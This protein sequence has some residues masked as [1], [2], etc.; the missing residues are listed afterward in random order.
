MRT[1]LYFRL[2]ALIILV[3]FSLLSGLAFSQSCTVTYYN[4]N[5]QGTHTDCCA[6]SYDSGG[7]GSAGDYSINENYTQTFYTGD[8]TKHYTVH[9][10]NFATESGF[11]FLSAYDGPNTASPLLGTWSGTTMPP[12][13]ATS[14]DYL[15]LKFTSDGSI[16]AAGWLAN[17]RCVGVPTVQ[18]CMG[19]IPICNST[20]STVVAYSGTGNVADEIP[21]TGGCP[22][23][24]CLLSGEKNDVWYTFT[25]QTGGTLNFDIN[26][27]AG[28]DDY[29]WAVYDLTG[30]GC[31]AIA[32][33]PASVQV[34]CNYSATDGLTGPDGGYAQSCGDASASPFNDVISAAAGH[35]YVINISNFTSSQSGYT[36]N[37]GGS[38]VVIDNVPPYMQSLGSVACGANVIPV[39]FSENLL[40]TSV[41]ET[42]F[43]VTGPGGP[44]TVTNVSGYGCQLNPNGQEND[45]FLTVSPALQTSG[46]YTVAL[47]G[48]AAVQD[49]CGNNNVAL[50]NLTFSISGVAA[51][52]SSSTNETCGLSNGSVTATQ[53]GGV[54]PYSYSWSNGGSTATISSL[55]AGTYTCTVTDNG[56]CKGI[57]SQT[58]TSSPTPVAPTS[59]TAD[60]TTYCAGAYPTINLSAAGGSGTTLHW[61]TS[62]G[63]ADIGTGT[64]LNIAAPASTTT[65]YAWWSNACG[66]STCQSVTITVNP[67]PVAPTSATADHTTF[68]AGAYP[69]INLSAAGGSGT[70]LH[71]STSCGG[72]DIGTGTPLNIA[73]PA[74]TTTYYAWWSNGCGNTTCQSVTVTVN[75]LPVAPTSASVDHNNF[76]PSTWPTINLSAVGGS[77]TTLNWSTSCGGAVI[78]TGTPLNIASPASTTTYYAWWT[79]GCGSTTCQSVTVNILST[80][81]P[82]TSVVVDNNNFCAGDYPTIT[83]TASGGSGATMN[84]YSG[85]CGGTSLGTGNPKTIA[86]P[87][88]TTT[89]YAAW[90]DACGT[91]TC[92][93]VTVNINPVPLAPTSATADFTT[94]CAG[95]HPTINLSAVGG[96]GTTLNWSTSCGGASIGTGTPLNIAA[97]ATTTTYYAY[98]TTSCGNSTCASVTITINPLPV[99]PTSANVDKNNFCPSSFPNITLTAAGGSGSTLNWYTGSCGGTLVGTGTPLIIAAPVVT[100]T[101]Y[102]AWSN[103]CGLSSCASITVNVFPL[104]VAPTSATADYTTFCAGAYPTINL[105]ATGGSG[106]VLN[107][108]T[109][110]GGAVIGTGTPLNIAAPATTTTYY[111]SWANSCGASTCASVTITVNPLPVA[112]T[113]ATADHTTFCTGAYPTINL[114][115]TGGS[116]TTLNWST[117]CGG[118][119]IG[120]GTPLNIPAPAATTTYYAWWT[121]GCGNST[122]QSVTITINPLPVAPTSATADFTTFCAGAYPTINL[123]ATGGS[124]ATLDWS[125]S[126]GGASIGT[127]T[128]LNIAAPA[129]T[130]TYYASWTNGCGTSTCAS[131]PIT[132]NPLPIA[133]AGIDATIPNGTSTTLNGSASGG[134]GSYSYSWSPAG[135]LVNA[136][137]QNPTTTNLPSTTVYTLTVTDLVTGCTGTDQVTITISGG[138]LSASATATPAA[139]CVGASSQL[140]AL[141][142]GGSG[143]YTYSWSSVPAGFSS[144]LINPVV[145]PLVTTDYTVSVNDGF[146]TVTANVTVTVNPL[147]IAYNVTGGGSYCAGGVGIPVCLSGSELGVDYQLQCNAVNVGSPM[148][149]TGAS[150][151]FG[152][153][154][155]AGTYTV[156]AT[157]ATTSCLNNMTGNV[158]ITIFANPTADA[159]LGATIP[160]GTSTSLSGSALGGSG[161]YTYSWSP[162]GLLVNPNIQNPT[163]TN[164]SSTTTYTLTVTDQ[165][166]GCTGTDQVT[167]TI[168][169]GP[170]SVSTSAT[171]ATL[172]VGGS[173]QLNALA[174]GG[175]GAYTYSWSSNPAGFSSLISN[176]L[177]S[178]IVTTIYTVS[179]NDGF[180]TVTSSVTVT[181]NPL[182]IVYNVTGGGAYCAGGAGLPVCLNGSELGVNYQLQCNGVNTGAPIAGTG[183]SICFGNQTTAGTYTVIATNATSS[184]QSTMNLSVVISINAN[185]I[186]NAG[187]D[188]SIPNGTSTTLSG[189]ASGGSGTYTYSWSPAASLVNANIQNPTTVNLSATTTFTLTVTDQVTGC[190]S[191]DQ[192]TVTITGGP[193]S[194]IASSTLPAVCLGGSTQ[195]LCTPSGGSGSYT[196]S[197]SSAPAGF[198]S[199][200]QNPVV[201]PLLTTT[202]TVTVNDGFSTVASSVIITVNP[203]PAANAG[204]DVN[205]CNGSSTTLTASGG[206]S[207]L[208]S[209]ATGLSAVNIASPIAAPTTN[210]TYIVTVTNAFGCSATDAVNVSLFA[211]IPAYAGVDQTICNG[212]T[213]YLNAS[214]GVSFSWSPVT[215]LNSTTIPNPLAT[216]TTNTTYVVQTTDGN[217]CTSSDNV[218]VNVNPNV[219]AFAGSDVTICSGSS[220]TLSASGG[221]NYTWSPA[222]GLTST[223]ISNPVATPLYTT[224]YIVTVSNSSGCSSTDAVTVTVN[225][226]VTANA[227]ADVNICSGSSVTLFASGGISYV[228]SPNVSLSATNVQSPVA[229]PSSTTTYTVVVTGAT[230]CSASDNITVTVNPTPNADAGIP[231]TICNHATAVLTA[232]GGSSYQWSNG[233]LTAVN[234]VSPGTSTTYVV[235]VSDI[236]G[237]SATDLVTVTVM[238]YTAPVITSNVPT[239]FCNAPI[240]V[241]LDAG[242]GYSAYQ[243]SN[244]LASQTINVTNAGSYYVIGTSAN[245]CSD[246]SNVVH[247]ASYPGPTPPVIMAD[248]PTSF[249]E[250]DQIS[251]TLSTSIPY[252]TYSWSSGSYTPTIHVTHTGYYW[253]TVTDSTGC[254]ATSLAPAHVQ[255]VPLPV[256][257][258]NYNAFG[259][260][261]EFFNYSLNDTSYYWTFGDG[262]NST[263]ENPIHTYPGPGNYTVTFIATNFCGSDTATI[264]IQIVSGNGIDESGIVQNLSIYPIPTKDLLDVSFEFSGSKSLDIKLVNTLGQLI[265]TESAENSLG[266]YHKVFSL[267]NYPT[268][269]YYLQIQT[270]QGVVTRKIVVN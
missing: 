219:V 8:P 265:Y 136:T 199:V 119:V 59:A 142:S 49:L 120:T 166:T 87:A 149:G 95:A 85:S 146:N 161:S 239:T 263:L 74:S 189:S 17:I 205:I 209:P 215:G 253:V 154:L 202:Y 190:T 268:G 12:N 168:T 64:P 176:P 2:K 167:I 210:M 269:V 3:F 246:T 113:S 182:P 98:W 262:A 75:P 42:D 203:I 137:L 31:G 160:N 108:S 244:G 243:W 188:I 231:V 140:N 114:S 191:T 207:Y 88:T 257:Y 46:T 172:C 186:A 47:T 222:I 158:S 78:G 229:S 238:P 156:I 150:I 117:S 109:S 251:V 220:T 54:A 131:V 27:V 93:N 89:Y 256:A 195:L 28:T 65:Y 223:N 43:T 249:C 258:M 135:L 73:A 6:D 266:K 86:A 216:P 201:T 68:C 233:V 194:A 91:T 111:A 181:V 212:Q 23:G 128:P 20:Y 52:I 139:I 36:V 171:P 144:T 83:L 224:T 125:T 25:T 163:T 14:G 99:A 127:G 104:P 225:P 71:W 13:L 235:T 45:Y 56:G 237:C 214:G 143:S 145:S 84:W 159:G 81:T 133:D 24:N 250:G 129:A 80:A 141:P 173:S 10:V 165:V 38:A 121:N 112:P 110:C 96:S 62:C 228:W 18:D 33:D 67:L 221:T 211:T 72:A 122:C 40:C 242:T 53:S 236:T 247:V 162:A 97:P 70:T 213:A 132:V 184:C 50:G 232:T 164:L 5:T 39:D 69:T 21:T 7:P 183:A 240:N 63:G 200:S 267:I 198:S 226:G 245:G 196:Y 9:F 147:P 260:Y 148:A 79:N 264:L 34:S 105:S 32:N 180:N 152:N 192:V 115:A 217:G 206:T 66:N 234:P 185:P 19:A 126:C 48:A 61:S 261:V 153:Q 55:A 51:S 29:D 101:Y 255:L 58:I 16:N 100:T 151:C 82:P 187:T 26:P 15:T 92:A 254:S 218:V 123:S 227:G 103:G 107:W 138:P 90:S 60:H 178:P 77:G 197:W 175:S 204:A 11:D 118:A 179:V 37:F 134:S 124:G 106:T 155:T 30:V 169:G 230:G 57:T 22:S 94:F 241:T 270:D 44:Y 157:N 4:I 248:G 102:A 35:T 170:L 193:L 208:W 76:C 177:V 259:T 252:Y 130:T 174:S 116:G 1:T 41:N